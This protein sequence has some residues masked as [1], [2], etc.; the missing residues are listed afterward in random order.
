MIF[1][2]C[3]QLTPHPPPPLVVCCFLN[4]RDPETHTGTPTQWGG[5]MRPVC[6]LHA[7]VLVT[8]WNIPLYVKADSWP[9]CN[10]GFSFIPWFPHAG[11][12]WATGLCWGAGRKRE[13]CDISVHDLQILWWGIQ[14]SRSLWE[15]TAC[16]RLMSETQ[17][18]RCMILKV[19]TT[20]FFSWEIRMNWA[21][22]G[23]ETDVTCMIDK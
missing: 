14:V 3:V 8:G 12:N 1:E 21:I 5:G 22:E 13:T 17:V 9:Q 11:G 20:C 6:L 15:C 19:V 18:V 4:M 10:I 23:E 7:C 2:V 16:S